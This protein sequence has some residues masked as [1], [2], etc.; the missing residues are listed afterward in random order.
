M[1]T[2]SPQGPSARDILL[3]RLRAVVRRGPF[4][5]RKSSLRAQK[6]ADAKRKHSEALASL[7]GFL[8]RQGPVSRQTRRAIERRA[9]FA[10]ANANPDLRHAPR[11]IRRLYSRMPVSLHTKGGA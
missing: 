4:A 7:Q 6:R 3:A 1:T 10:E 11:A 2:T 5:S 9:R 8:D